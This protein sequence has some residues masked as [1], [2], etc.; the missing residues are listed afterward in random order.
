MAT[1]RVGRALVRRREARQAARRRPLL[2]ARPG[3]P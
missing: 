1:A 3:A 2:A